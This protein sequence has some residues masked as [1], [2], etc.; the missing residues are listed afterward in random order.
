MPQANRLPLPSAPVKQQVAN[1]QVWNRAR[2]ADTA[3][4]FTV[5]YTGRKTDEIIALLKKH[6]VRTVVDIRQNPISMYRPDLSKNNLAQLLE[7]A[8]MYY[9]HARHL[10]VPRDLDLV[11][12]DRHTVVSQSPCLPK[13]VRASGSADVHR[14]RSPR[15]PSAPAL[16]C[17]GTNGIDQLRSLRDVARRD[18]KSAEGHLFLEKPER[19]LE[20]IPFSFSYEF[21]CDDPACKRHKMICTDWEMGE[22]YR[23]WKAEYGD[24]WEEKFRQRYESEMISKYDTHLYVGTVNRYPGT[25]IIVGLFY[26][27]RRPDTGQTDLFV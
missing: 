8:G 22:S 1:K 13:R 19:E 10:G 12:H 3:D 23:K 15:V 21:R 14:D 9:S 25:W 27:G 7:K 4:F 2:S 17:S 16:S 18:Q 20:K 11:R 24:Q 5:G 6:H 26:P